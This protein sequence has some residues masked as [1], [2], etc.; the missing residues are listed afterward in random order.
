[1]PDIGII[2]VRY[3]W[4]RGLVDED[5]SI[6]GDQRA[7]CECICQGIGF[8]VVEEDVKKMRCI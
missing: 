7:E 5:C 4:D 2:G 1:L 8:K 6:A 3:Q